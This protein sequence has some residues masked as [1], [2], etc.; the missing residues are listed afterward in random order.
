MEKFIYYQIEGFL[1]SS[2]ISY[3]IGNIVKFADR[4]KAIDTLEDVLKK[5]REERN[6]ECF[7][8]MGE[9]V[10]D[11]IYDDKILKRYRHQFVFKQKRTGMFYEQTFKVVEHIISYKK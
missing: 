9:L 8:S 1:P 6:G 10:N 2:F 5:W 11:N 3:H 7:N 4:Q